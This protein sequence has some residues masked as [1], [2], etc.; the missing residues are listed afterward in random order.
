MLHYAFAAVAAVA[1]TFGT[2]SELNAQTPTADY[3]VT[4]DKAGRYCIETDA[5]T[6][7]RLKHVECRTVEQWAKDG[8]TFAHAQGA[9]QQK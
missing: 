5:E 6:G 1:I 3:K 2:V 7:S 4:T 9:S 8:V